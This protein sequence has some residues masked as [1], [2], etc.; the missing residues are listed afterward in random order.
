M[1]IHFR[2]RAIGRA[3]ALCLLSP[4][5]LFAG[6]ATSGRWL[7][8]FNP[9]GTLE[10]T[11]KRRSEG[12]GHWN[13]SSSSTYQLRDFQG[14]ARPSGAGDV[15]VT[16]QMVR[17][18]GT[19]AFEGQL[20][21][22]GGSG[23]FAFTANP[24]YLAALKSM[25][26]ATPDADETFSLAVHD[27]SRTYIRELDAL[28]Y[29]KVPLDDLL[30]LRIH[31]A[32]PEFIRELK[33]LGYT[34]LSTDD[35]VSMSIHEATPAFIR[36]LKALGYDRLTADELVSMRIHDVTPGIIRELKA[37]GIFRTSSRTSSSRWPS[38][39]PRRSSS[40]T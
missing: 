6:T 20:D 27:V 25:G 31:D 40:G 2:F 18:A 37:L 22:A 10:L 4:A 28:G 5:L 9:D 26:Y 36:E 14:L 30:S 23:R 32:G 16:F 7:V 8:D 1:S 34:G 35:L 17:D 12:S 29:R 3:L 39:T 38:T 24:E 33:A 21:A 13:W 11:L 19:V 15:A